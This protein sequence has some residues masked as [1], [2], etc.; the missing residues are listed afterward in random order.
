M[1][2]ERVIMEDR[3]VQTEKKLM[4]HYQ[5]Y[6]KLQIKDV[7]KFLHQSSYGCEHLVEDTDK[8]IEYIRNEVTGYQFDKGELIE[9]L[10]GDFCRVHLDWIKA[11]L[12][13]KTL[14]ILFSLSAEPVENG[15]RMLEEKLVVFKEMVNKGLLP[16][17]L[18]E[19][20]REIAEWRVN[21]YM[22]CRHSEEFRSNYGP[23]YRVI[24]KEFALFLPLLLQIDRK[25]QM[26]R[27]TTAIE[28][29][30]A[31]GKTTLSKVLEKVYGATILHMDD[32]FLRPEQ[33]TQERFAE[34][35]GNID[36]ERFLEEVLIPLK[37]NKPID[38]RVF[39]CSTF[40]IKPA[41][42]M[43]LSEVIIIE[44]AYSMHPKLAQYYD[45]SAFLNVS[46]ELQKKR[47]LKRNTPEMAKRFFEQW[48]PMEHKYFE[49]MN[50]KERCDIIIDI[51]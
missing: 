48:I 43:N 44:G 9:E 18:Q 33:R 23:G 35:G 49:Q 42:R 34:P 12:S 1:L 7:F 14:G 5:S 25:M 50:V 13:A 8:V 24:R 46:S 47:I 37:D 15:K 4:E 26:G 16:F 3:K 40:T 17:N 28:G 30:S 51:G 27:V 36:W 38:Y 11:G 22:A 20:E 10:D 32:F 29:G 39:D 19:V 6:P 2:G 21:G 41:I 31:S 45:L